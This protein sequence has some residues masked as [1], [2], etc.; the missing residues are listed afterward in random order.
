[1]SPWQQ[2]GV[3]PT[4]QLAALQSGVGTQLPAALQF[5]FTPHFLHAVPP[6]PHALGVGGMTQKLPE[7]QPFGHVPALHVG[8]S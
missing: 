4:P 2:P 7:Q 8:G 6:T 1:M 5:S 3:P